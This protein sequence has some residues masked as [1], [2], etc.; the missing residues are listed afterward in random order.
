[1]T[2]RSHGCPPLG[3]ERRG[4]SVSSEQL[5]STSRPSRASHIGSVIVSFD[6]VVVQRRRISGSSRFDRRSASTE[7]FERRNVSAFDGEVDSRTADLLFFGLESEFG[8]DEC[9]EFRFAFGWRG[10][11]GLEA[12]VGDDSIADAERADGVILVEPWDE[13][14][15]LF[16]VR[17]GGA[18][19]TAQEGEVAE[20]FLAGV[21]PA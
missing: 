15:E 14:G 8:F 4:T 21:L 5:R 17:H 16:A 19:G 13:C 9:I 6:S 10:G 18:V 1:M 11:S 3:F 12:R 7:A 2:T 20:V